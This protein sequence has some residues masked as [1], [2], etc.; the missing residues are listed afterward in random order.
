MGKTKDLF[1]KIRDTKGTLHAK[2]GSIKDRNCRDLTE[3][4]DIK[5]WQ[6]IQKNCTKKVLMTQITTMV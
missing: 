1:K 4:E 2:I 6:H 3:A 5:R